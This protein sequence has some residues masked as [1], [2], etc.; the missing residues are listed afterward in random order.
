MRKITHEIFAA[1]IAL[2]L[3]NPDI[4]Y[5]LPT[6]LTSVLGGVFPDIDVKFKHRKLMHNIFSLTIIGLG[7]LYFTTFISIRAVPTLLLQAFF[8][9]YFTHMLL[10]LFTKRGVALMWPLTSKTFKITNRR[11]DDFSI[12]TFFSSLGLG[13]LILYIVRITYNMVY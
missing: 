7:P 9:G 5:T 2:L 11:Y 6:I 13:A 3:I 10:D 12:N 8:I 4:T 1:G